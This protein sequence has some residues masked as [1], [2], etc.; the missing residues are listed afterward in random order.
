MGLFFYSEP[1]KFIGHHGKTGVEDGIDIGQEPPILVSVVDVGIVG[2]ELQPDLL[3]VN[4]FS[5]EPDAIL[6]NAFMVLTSLP[7]L[8]ASR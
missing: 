3:L 4:H 7:D 1:S 6:P 5:G 8:S 2:G